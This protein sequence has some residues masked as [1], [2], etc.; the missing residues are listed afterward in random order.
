MR[1]GRPLLL[2]TT[3]RKR[4]PGR[5]WLRNRNM[6]GY[7]QYIYFFGRGHVVGLDLE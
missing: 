4:S 1:R 6:H 3:T 7:A 5:L 2:R